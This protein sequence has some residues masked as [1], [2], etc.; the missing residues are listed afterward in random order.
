MTDDDRVDR[1]RAELVATDQRIGLEA[2]LAAAHA[3][4][5]RL[6]RV[7]AKLEAERSEP[8][9][10]PAPRSGVLGRLRRGRA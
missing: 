7:I 2:S 5:A 8:V 3:E 1:E 9:Q 10:Q 6:R 4:I